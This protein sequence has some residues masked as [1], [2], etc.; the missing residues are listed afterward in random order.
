MQVKMS[1]VKK[2]VKPLQLFNMFNILDLSSSLVALMSGEHRGY[3]F[4][5]VPQAL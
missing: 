3:S 2:A 5:S 4:P 1:A